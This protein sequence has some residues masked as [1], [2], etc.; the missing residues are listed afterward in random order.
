MHTRSVT[1]AVLA[2]C[3]LLPGVSRAYDEQYGDPFFFPSARV[4]NYAGLEVSAAHRAPDVKLTSGTFAAP[5]RMDLPTYNYFGIAAEGAVR[6]N[7]GF[8]LTAGRLTRAP[9]PAN[10]NFFE[11]VGLGVKTRKVGPSLWSCFVAEVDWSHRTQSKI[12]SLGLPD[13]SWHY[14]SVTPG[15]TFGVLIAQRLTIEWYVG[16][17][18]TAPASITAAYPERYGGVK[19]DP[20]YFPHSEMTL[21]VPVA[22]RFGV[23][24][25]PGGHADLEFRMSNQFRLSGGFDNSEDSAKAPWNTRYPTDLA[26]GYRHVL[27]GRLVGGAAVYFALNER[28]DPGR[29]TYGFVLTAKYAYY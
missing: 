13:L 29:E 4:G 24:I 18:F 26:V 6:S 10:H 2:V 12:D 19:V 5:T 25:V 21:N 3:T 23:Q 17:G 1:L 22:W 20:D 14:I 15:W 28:S 11:H 8:E 7:T 27:L 9:G 16:V